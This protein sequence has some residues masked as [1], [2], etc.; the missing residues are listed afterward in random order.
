MQE[1]EAFLH[2][3][4]PGLHT[5]DPVEH[6]QDRRALAGE[7][8]HKKPAEKI[9][10]WMEVLERTHTS[11]RDDPGVLE[12]IKKYYHDAYVITPDAVPQSYFDLQKRLARERGHGDI[13]IT[14]ELRDQI[15]DALIADQRS[16]LD[17]WVD[18]LASPDADSF[19][20]WAKYWAFTGMVKL[21]S[22]DKE[23]YAF[24]TR[25]KGTVAP[26]PDLDREALA[27]AVDALIK[28][29]Q[30]EQIPLDLDNP[31]HVWKLKAAYAR[32]DKVG[33]RI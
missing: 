4:T 23:K 21:S 7:V 33:C 11:H 15:T 32:F 31:D 27:V 14:P 24:G 3:R 30:K 13:D 6:E 10:D 25:D 26:F 29:A 17:L 12:R 2:K 18:Y 28:Q 16:T 9:S 22:Y 19:P 1:G 20:M 5:S 8:V